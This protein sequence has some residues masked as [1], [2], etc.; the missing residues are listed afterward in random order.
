MI[1]VV[2]PNSLNFINHFLHTNSDYVPL[3]VVETIIFYPLVK[4]RNRKQV[5]GQTGQDPHCEDT[6]NVTKGTNCLWL[7]QE[8]AKF[9][10][11][12]QDNS[13]MVPL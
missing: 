6:F 10:R 11:M 5:I 7:L 13:S 3:F 8:K 4:H 9:Y 2:Q 1:I 12:V